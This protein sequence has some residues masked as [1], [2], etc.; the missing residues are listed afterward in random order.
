MG[1]TF[2]PAILIAAQ[3]PI[4][5]VGFVVL[6]LVV[7]ALDLGVF[8]RNPHVVESKEAIV[9][10]CVWIGLA[11]AFAVFVWYDMG[12]EKGIEFITGFVIEKS[13][14]V[15]NLFVMVLVFTSFGIPRMYQHRVLFWGIL[16]ALVSR[17]L[18]IFLGVQ[19]IE[20][21]HFVIYAFGAF[22][23][24]TGIRMVVQRGDKPDPRKNLVLRIFKRFVR[25]TDTIEGK[26]FL[27]RNSSGRTAATP[28]MVALV[29]VEAMD[30]VFAVD[31]IPAIFAVTTDPFI[32]FTSNIFAILGLRS[33][34]FLLADVVERFVHLE[35][36]LSVILAYVGVKMLLSDVAPIPTLISLGVILAIL[37][38]TIVTSI[39]ANRRRERREAA[40]HSGN[41]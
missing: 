3:S 13:L 9:W 24:F 36:G 10:T 34:Y 14:S 23:L 37:A 40:A 19:L 8:N 18:M 20:R 6:I 16:G 7:L 12:A 32:V 28:L 22:L 21:F 25:T 2:L 30:I 39:I 41:D 5:W 33:L 31:S 4:V 11:A 15:D 17:G 26:H 29:V 38:I 35:I 1:P 27:T